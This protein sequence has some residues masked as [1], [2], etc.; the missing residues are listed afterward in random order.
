MTS[1]ISFTKLI[2]DDIRRRGW[3]AV[4]TCIALF[5]MMPVYAL[6]YL[7]SFSESLSDPY[8][9]ENIADSFPGLI[10]GASVIYSDI[11]LVAFAILAILIALTGFGYIHSREKLDF[12]H[13]LPVKRSRWFATVYLAGVIILIVP[14]VICAALT[15]A[16]GAAE[17]VMTAQLFARCAQA[18]LGG[19][20]G[21]FVIYSS[22]VF[23]VM[24]TGRAVTGL[25]A[26]LTVIVYPVMV[27]SVFSLFQSSFFDSFYAAGTTWADTLSRYLSPG[28]LFLTLARTGA[29]WHLSPSCVLASILMSAVLIAGAALLYR[30]RPSEAAGNAIAF[31]VL[32]PILKVLIVIP[33]ALFVGVMIPDLMGIPG[34]TSLLLLSLL[35]AVLL[36]IIIEFL[37]HTDFRKMLKGWKSSLLSI[38]G[39]LAVVCVFQFDLFGYDTYLP[40]EG[41]IEA[42]SIRPDS[43]DT[44]FAYLDYEAGSEAAAGVYAPPEYTSELYALAQSGIENLESGIST[45]FL[46]EAP[47]S[48]DTLAYTPTVFR[49]RLSG[50]RTVFRKYAVRNEDLAQVLGQLLDQ[51]DFR[52]E[53][54]PIFQIDKEDVTGI[55]L[56]DAYT[57]PEDL[58]LNASQQKALLDAYEKDVLNV[59]T[60]T[61]LNGTPIAELT[62]RMPDPEAVPVYSS[63]IYAMDKAST[64]DSTQISMPMLYLYPEY[65]NTL[66]LLEE[67]GC[68][69]R[70]EI[71]PADVNSAVLILSGGSVQNGI[72]DDVLSGLSDTAEITTDT[73]GEGG[74]NIVVYSEED[75]ALILGN[76][77]PSRNGLLK[78][79]VSSGDY[80]EIAYKDGPDGGFSLE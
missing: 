11:R 73:D 29:F 58:G 49:Y 2:L 47:L 71:D 41:K 33:T 66:D 50:G 63:G 16:V 45:E 38:C 26:A 31:P 77:T 12:F 51:E 42:I 40:D 48:E 70:T 8:V 19:I 6:L 34:N 5:L 14:Y 25:L 52:K 68:T 3:L 15:A 60:D 18:A 36:C 1:K 79:N 17:G 9:Y 65:T 28:G 35:T 76:V 72:Y 39:V 64:G 57:V 43:F 62:V 55:S 23:A 27:L 44:Y 4:M 69:I 24:L 22:S 54:F 21:I 74:S 67:Y 46:Y 59:S 10:N 32:A 53:L 13:S 80:L 30:V 61:L 56:T 37:Y 20:L 75:I 7:S 78:S